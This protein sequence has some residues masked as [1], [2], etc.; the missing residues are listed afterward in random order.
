M[1]EHNDQ[2]LDRI[3]VALGT[4]TAD[5]AKI[6]SIQEAQ[7]DTQRLQA[8]SIRDLQTQDRERR[9]TPWPTLIGLAALLV[10]IGG[11]ALS[12]VV[13]RLNAMST[14]FEAHRDRDGHPNVLARVDNLERDVLTNEQRINHMQEV[15]LQ[16]GQNSAALKARF[17]EVR[18]RLNGVD[19]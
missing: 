19:K 9:N 2:R 16:A 4:L 1:D 18:A 5:V 13:S 10:T 3:E 8:A 12:P 15:A 17:D 14:E 7:A 6:V 11:L